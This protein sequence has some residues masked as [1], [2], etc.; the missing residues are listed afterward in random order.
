MPFEISY[1][2]QMYGRYFGVIGVRSEVER[3][4]LIKGVA[5]EQELDRVAWGIF[6][7]VTEAFETMQGSFPN[8]IDASSQAS[9][10]RSAD[11]LGN[12]IAFYRALRGYSIEQ[13]GEWIRPTTVDESLRRLPSGQ[14]EKN[15]SWDVT[16]ELLGGPLDDVPHDTQWLASHVSLLNEQQRWFRFEPLGLK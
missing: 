10:Y 3:V 16:L 11:L 8:A 12:R 7:E 6:R 15:H 9:S 1:S 5:N 14:F 4:Y 13:V 2:Q